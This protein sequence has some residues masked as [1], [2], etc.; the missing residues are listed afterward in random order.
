VAGLVA[1]TPACA[2]IMPLWAAALGVVAGILCALAVS[3]KYKLGFDDSLDVVGVHFVGGW[4]GSLWIGLFATDTVNSWITD[5]AILGASNGLF[6]GGGLEQLV[7]QAEGSAIVSVYS[8]G[9]AFVIGWVVK[10]IM[11]M[12]LRVTPEVEVEGID[13][14]EHAESAYDFSPGG[15][16]SGAFALAGIGAAPP[17]TKAGPSTVEEEEPQQPAKVTG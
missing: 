3:L 15:S 8:F 13:V 5:P 12:R 17:A 10:L 4:I 7:R 6:Y 16:S 1:I 9:M 2:Y 14:A 11:G